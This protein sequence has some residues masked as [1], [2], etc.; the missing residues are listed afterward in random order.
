MGFARFAAALRRCKTVAIDT[1]VVSYFLLGHAAYARHTQAV[2]EQVEAGALRAVMSSIS[3][4]EMLTLP[5]ERND[6]ELTGRIEAFF[7]EFPNLSVAPFD[8]QLARTTAAVR[9]ETRVALSDAAIIATAQRAR[10]D[11]LISNE[12]R[13]RNRFLTP[14]LLLLD[15]FR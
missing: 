9:A 3:V 2:F 5:V 4:A 11:A 7:N 10:V 14:W 6:A 1:Q 13:W 15:D 8:S 12:G